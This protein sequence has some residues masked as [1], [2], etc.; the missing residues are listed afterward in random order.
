M[1]AK[2]SKS[3][4]SNISEENNSTLYLQEIRELLTKIEQNTRRQNFLKRH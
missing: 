1:A 4:K 3:R 2:R